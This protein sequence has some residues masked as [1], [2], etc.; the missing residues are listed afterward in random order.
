[1]PRHNPADTLTDLPAQIARGPIPDID[2]MLM[3]RAIPHNITL[4]VVEDSRY[5]SDALRLISGRLGMRMRRAETIEA[6]RSH[7]RTYLPDVVMIDLG[8]PDGRGE[9]LIRQIILS[10]LRPALVLGTSGAEDGRQRSLAAGADGYLA[11]PVESVATLG[12]LIQKLCPDLAAKLP[13]QTPKVVPDPLALRE[14]LTHAANLLAN[15]DGFSRY[16]S[17]IGPFLA[18]IAGC[19]HDEQLA[20]AV[21]GVSEADAGSG[22]GETVRRLEGLIAGRIRSTGA[23]SVL[24]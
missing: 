12:Q 10:T 2:S 16:A 3:L 18:G 4:L 14:D 13:D 15:R 11:K 22:Q 20:T 7:L 23:S 9:E 24:G 21:R 6:A 5:A 17:Y 8:L 1:M 19:A